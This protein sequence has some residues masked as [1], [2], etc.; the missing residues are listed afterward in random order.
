[1]N[2]IGAVDFLPTQR[3]LEVSLIDADYYH[4]RFSS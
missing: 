1:M 2:E 3:R 4:Q